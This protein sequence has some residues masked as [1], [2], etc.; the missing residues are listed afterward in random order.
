MKAPLPSNEAARLK[1]LRRYKVLDTPPEPAFDDITRI[2]AHICGTPLAL[3]SLVD[4]ERQWFKSRIGVEATETPREVAF[5]AHAIL[6]DDLLEVSDALADE[7]FA[8]NPLVTGE[9]RIRFYA[10]APL[11]DPDGHALGTLCVADHEPHR[12]TPEQ[13]DALRALARQVIVQLELRRRLDELATA[14]A[15][16]RLAEKELDRFFRLSPDLLCIASLDGRFQR[17]NPAWETVLGFSREELMAAPYLDFVHPEDRERTHAEAQKLSQ[18]TDALQFENR[19]R[20]RDGRYRWLQWTSRAAVQQGLIYAVARDVTELRDAARRQAAGYAVTKVLAD[21]DSLAEATPRILEAVC[22]NLGWEMGALWIVDENSVALRNVEIWH[23]PQTDLGEFEAITRSILF[24]PGIG[25]PGRVWTSGQPAWIPDV[26]RDSNFPRAPYAERVG[27][28]GAFGFPIRQRGRV[29]GVLEFFSREI[30]QP[31][32]ALLEMFDAIGSQVGQFMERK[33]AKEALRRYAR[34]L[35]SA[36]QAEEENAARLAQLVK[37]LEGARHRAEEATLAKSRLLA[38]MSHE[39]RTPMNAILGMT[40]LALDTRLSREQREYIRTA[41]H[42]AQSLLALIN[43]ILDYSKVEAG[44]LEIDRLPFSLRDTLD[45]TLRVLALRAREKRLELA[46]HVHAGVPDALVSD[47]GRLRQIVMNLVGN[48]IKFTEQGEVLVEVGMESATRNEAVLS[49]AVHDTGI[50]IPTD[51]Q[52]IVF[53]PFAQADASTTRK[54]GGTGLGLAI[55]KQLVELMGGRVWVESEEGRG[56]TFHFTARFALQKGAVRR[57]APERLRSFRVLVVDDNQTTRRI[58]QEMLAGWNMQSE[59]AAGGAEALDLLRRSR[60]ERT[61]FALAV[62]DADMPQMD[63]FSLA[64]QIQRSPENGK[65]KIL[66]LTPPATGA[67]ERCRTLGLAGWVH[68]PVMQS[69]LYDALVTALDS[70]A[71]ETGPQR[72]R[73][74]PVRKGLRILLAEDNPVNQ[75]LAVK[76]LEKQGHRVAVAATGREALAAVEREPFDVV[77][78]DVQMPEMDGLE[79]T[80][81]LR[82]RERTTGGH[83][84]VIAMTAH[85]MSGDRERCLEAGM[86]AYVAKPIQK[87]QL[88]AALQS[89]STSPA[90]V[91]S[92]VFDE[93]ELMERVEGDA[94]LAAEMSELFQ[95]N[96]PQWIRAI[97]EAAAKGDADSLESEA[98]RLKG[99]AAGLGAHTAA[100]IAAQLES[101]AHARNLENAGAAC[102]ALEAA[103]RELG[104]VLQSFCAR[105]RRKSG[106]AGKRP[107]RAIAARRKKRTGSR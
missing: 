92:T 101:L 104:D 55:V 71:R 50:G 10:G 85:A 66:L 70:G 62:I 88:V 27:L 30:R 13:R 31:D 105:V 1:A 47:P 84:P 77:L 78:M 46:C 94:R 82:E 59:A 97:R 15:E 100:E 14:M 20:T 73:R 28:H 53:D 4:A 38:N 80:R 86:D 21:A 64:E 41:H 43:D 65:L 79:A 74:V 57:R 51:K 93:A 24:Q 7:R 60:K 49:F 54:Y 39:I 23:L 3:V 107:A 61:P 32:P 103:C 29:V 63:G 95:A 56:S 5:C 96:A 90:T 25:L 58:L 8:H 12:L 45:E 37:E 102:V 89:V 81:A 67:D 40:E 34:E 52:A 35:E 18:G 69:E 83:M 87:Q 36:K 76:L 6:G 16:R 19:Y 72:M 68:K 98:H 99:S 91:A 44:K 9:P 26:V 11:I 42:S 22:L 106:R 33:Q 2:A 17:L 75:R 48:A